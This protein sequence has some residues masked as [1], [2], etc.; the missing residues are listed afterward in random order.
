MNSVCAIVGKHAY[1][2]HCEYDYMYSNHACGTA[3]GMLITFRCKQTS[4][5]PR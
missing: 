1:L 4:S 5:S 2:L 3:G